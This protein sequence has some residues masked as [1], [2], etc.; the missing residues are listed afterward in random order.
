MNSTSS[1]LLSSEGQE[2]R[3]FLINPDK[4]VISAVVLFYFSNYILSSYFPINI[5][6]ILI[7]LPIYLIFFLTRDRFIDESCFSPWFFLCSFSVLGITYLIAE[8]G[9][10]A[11]VS[12]EMFFLF[13]LPILFAAVMRAFS[14]NF[15]PFLSKSFL[16]FLLWQ[17]FVVLGQI[18]DKLIGVGLGLPSL[19]SELPFSHYSDMLSGTF[20]NAND[21][22]ATCGMIFLF[23]MIYR[24]FAVKISNFAIC[25]C[26]ILAL[27]TLSRFVIVFMFFSFFGFLLIKSFF[28]AAAGF[29]LISVVFLVLFFY[30][31]E[32][33]YNY[34]FVARIV[35]RIETIFIIFSGGF[36]SDYS[37]SV[38]LFSYIQFFYN[39]DNLGLGSMTFKDYSLFFG[40]L[41]QK[42]QLMTINPHSFVAEVGYW[43]GWAGLV[44]F[45]LF[46][47]FLN[48]KNYILFF[49]CLL[50]FFLLTMVSSSVFG[51]FMIF[52]AFFSVLGLLVFPE[53]RI[54]KSF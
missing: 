13:S 20:Y 53:S 38:R 51:N 37:L 19:D 26:F 27:A 54:S 49:Y 32:Y 33:F 43:L 52:V 28:K 22:A 46:I 9:S 31:Q 42:Y 16:I 6:P 3:G 50:S 4:V 2:R 24:P 25:I 12:M 48:P 47:I 14:F 30:A 40:D 44:T 45:G 36:S 7:G 34:Q 35:E 15:V 29:L 39:I 11:L 10:A 41:E 8:K 23:F 17:L 1:G 18:S 21:L 5:A